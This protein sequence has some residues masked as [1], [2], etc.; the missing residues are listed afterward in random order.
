MGQLD[1]YSRAERAAI[2][3]AG[4]ALQPR[5]DAPGAQTVDGDWERL[6][7]ER[8]WADAQ[9]GK[10]VR[11]LLTNAEPAESFCEELDAC[12]ASNPLSSKEMATLTVTAWDW[13]RREL[14]G[15]GAGNG[16]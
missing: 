8:F 11:E 2:D 16:R 6:E 5:T 14:L 7:A 9:L 4:E 10:K 1:E 13:L 15:E 12:P 3:P